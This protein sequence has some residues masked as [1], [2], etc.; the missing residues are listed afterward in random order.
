M[1][2][3]GGI[4][5]KPH[6]DM[7]VEKMPGFPFKKNKKYSAGMH[8]SKMFQFFIFLKLLN[9]ITGSVVHNVYGQAAVTYR[10][11][12]DHRSQAPYVERGWYLGGSPPG[13]TPCCRQHLVR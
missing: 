5:E 7:H 2:C 9:F 1:Q 13:D 4:L 11:P 6:V 12:S 10:F 3:T 8:K